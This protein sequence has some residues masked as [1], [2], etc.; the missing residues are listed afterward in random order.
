LVNEPIMGSKELVTRQLVH[1]KAMSEVYLIASERVGDNSFQIEAQWP[2]RHFFFDAGSGRPDLVLVAETLRQATILTAH[3]YFAVPHQHIFLMGRLEAHLI[4]GVGLPTSVPSEIV[5]AVDVDQVRR[6]S[7]GVTALRTRLTFRCG[8]VSI[9]E[10]LGELQIL[11]PGIYARIR[12]RAT[13]SS[14]TPFDGSASDRG[15][16]LVHPDGAADRWELV[17]DRRHPVFFDHPLDHVPGMLII[18]AVHQLIA[19]VGGFPPMHITGFDG[20]F[21]AFLDLDAAVF[22]AGL[23]VTASPGSSS[24]EVSLNVEQHGKVAA[25][26]TASGEA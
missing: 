6:G 4:A 13:G 23:H 12:P 7:R 20:R 15:V 10:G 5:V 1:R 22:L 24:V 26:I 18:E 21:S 14:D 9:A 25:V 3:R 16:A 8:D 17:I 2:R 19:D 11:E